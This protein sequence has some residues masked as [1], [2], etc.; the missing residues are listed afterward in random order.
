MLKKR[1][2]EIPPYEEA[3]ITTNNKDESLNIFNEM[4]YKK[5]LSDKVLIES[6]LNYRYVHKNDNRDTVRV[7]YIEIDPQE[8][9]AS[10]KATARKSPKEKMILKKTTDQVMTVIES[11]ENNTHV[12]LISAIKF[13]QGNYKELY[14]LRLYR[15]EHFVHKELLYDPTV[16]IL[17]PKVEL[18]S[19]EESRK[20]LSERKEQ[21]STMLRCCIDDPVVKFLGGT[22]GQ[23]LVYVRKV[24]H[25]SQVRNTLVYR[26][27]DNSAIPEDKAKVNK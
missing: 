26:F 16:H 23:V 7:I 8:R 12:I 20:F 5:A 19:M 4:F 14:D 24:A 25:L 2:Y 1:G 10:K 3:M 17:Q 22:F 9:S 6:K 11:D 13:T 21:A 27:I 15:I 18:L